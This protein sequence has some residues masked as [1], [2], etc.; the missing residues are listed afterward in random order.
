[1]VAVT[2]GL[3]KLGE[4]EE[5]GALEGVIRWDPIVLGSDSPRLDL[6]TSGD[7]V[8]IELAVGA[9]VFMPAVEVVVVCELKY[10]KEVDA[11][12]VH[13][14]LV[15]GVTSGTGPQIFCYGR[16]G[17]CPFWNGKGSFENSLIRRVSGVA[18]QLKGDKLE[19][20]IEAEGPGFDETGQLHTYGLSIPIVNLTVS[21]RNH[22]PLT[23]HRGRRAIQERAVSKPDRVC[24]P[25]REEPLKNSNCV[26]LGRNY[27]R[28]SGLCAV[29][30]QICKICTMEAQ[31]RKDGTGIAAGF[32]YMI[33]NGELPE[34]WPLETALNEFTTQIWVFR[35]TKQTSRVEVPVLVDQQVSVLR[36][37]Q[38]TKYS[39]ILGVQSQPGS[40]VLI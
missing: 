7:C 1:M 22:K 28:H 39:K 21:K 30:L 5:V 35:G 27:C 37:I 31:N 8:V 12:D 34:P 26:L 18:G 36:G 40:D 2:A 25:I 20:V 19:V 11:S 9:D 24:E 23:N 38:G 6:I 33:R 32:A 29:P 13:C 10:C 4:F 15:M 16:R 17:R 14:T 3:E